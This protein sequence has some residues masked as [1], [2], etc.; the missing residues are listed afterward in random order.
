MLN[1]LERVD[2]AEVAEDTRTTRVV[3]VRFRGFRVMQFRGPA[4]CRAEKV[5]G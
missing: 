4:V 2:H 1:P 5:V 3:S